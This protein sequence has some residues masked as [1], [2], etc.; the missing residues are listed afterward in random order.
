AATAAQAQGF[1]QI[2]DGNHTLIS[3]PTGSGK[4]LA[5]F[6]VAIDRLVSRD[7][8]ETSGTRVLY[9]SPLRAL[10]FDVEKNLRAPIVGIRHAAER[11]GTSFVEPSVAIWP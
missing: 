10:A 7:A 4:T 11:I 1:A 5:A 8:Q 6:L 2:L 9:V 3:A